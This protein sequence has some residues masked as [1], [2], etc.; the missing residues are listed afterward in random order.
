MIGK[1]VRA[2]GLLGC[3]VDRDWIW[4][5]TTIL[6]GHHH[7]RDLLLRAAETVTGKIAFTKKAL[8]LLNQLDLN[9]RCE[10]CTECK[11]AVMYVGEQNLVPEARIAPRVHITSACLWRGELGVFC[12]P[13]GLALGLSK[14]SHKLSQ[15]SDLGSISHRPLQS[16]CWS[17]PET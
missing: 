9:E 6:A 8:P 5:R 14:S 10:E 13:S 15:A 16:S 17:G 11:S 12:H 7:A 1:G 2:G 4:R 3:P